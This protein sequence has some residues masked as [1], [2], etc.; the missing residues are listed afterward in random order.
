M[1]GYMAPEFFVLSQSVGRIIGY[2]HS[3]SLCCEHNFIRICYV[4]FSRRPFDH[5][6]DVTGRTNVYRTK[7]I[8]V[9]NVNHGSTAA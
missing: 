3:Q 6:N 4:R 1:S 8:F 5:V 2:S 7:S 9:K